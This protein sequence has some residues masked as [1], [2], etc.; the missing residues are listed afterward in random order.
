MPPTDHRITAALKEWS[1][2]GRAGL[3]KVF[4]LAYPDLRKIA[5]RELKGD[6]PQAGRS[7]ADLTNA[8]FILLLNLKNSSWENRHRF[9]AFARRKFHHI[10]LDDVRG[11]KAKIRGGRNKHVDDSKLRDVP[12]IDPGFEEHEIDIFLQTLK[13]KRPDF[14]AIL[15]LKQEGWTNDEIAKKLGIGS[16]TVERKWQKA[17][18]LVAV[19]LKLGQGGTS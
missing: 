19:T 7:S 4:S 18:N 12:Q 3:D 10:V 2:K 11:I 15:T 8:L 9:F 1:R 17:R 13:D 6:D 5:R 16:A 14:Y